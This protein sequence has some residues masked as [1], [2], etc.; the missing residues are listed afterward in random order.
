MVN[1][2]QCLQLQH[3]DCLCGCHG[4]QQEEPLNRRFSWKRC[5]GVCHE[6]AIKTQLHFTKG[7]QFIL[8][9]ML[10]LP[11]SEGCLER[12][13]SLIYDFHVIDIYCNWTVER[14]KM[15]L[16]MDCLKS[17]L[18]ALHISAEDLKLSCL[19]IKTGSRFLPR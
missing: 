12:S 9:W 18:E 4:N 8:L 1:V 17:I 3:C 16:A 14:A 11:F 10:K 15:M 2:V 7:S 5:E 13:F 19:L 6:P